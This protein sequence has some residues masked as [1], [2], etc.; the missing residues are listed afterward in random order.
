MDDSKSLQKV[1]EEDLREFIIESVNIDRLTSKSKDF[2]KNKKMDKVLNKFIVYSQRYPKGKKK[3]YFSKELLLN[4]LYKKFEKNISDI[5]NLFENGEDICPYLHR[6][7]KDFLFLDGLLMDWGII[8]LHL[9][10][11]KERKKS[12]LDKFILYAF[13]AG[14]TIGFIDITEHDFLQQ[15]LLQVIDD[16]WPMILQ[17]TTSIKGD[18][19]EREQLKTLRSKGY[20]YALE[21]NGKTF[22][23]GITKVQNMTAIIYVFNRLEVLAQNIFSSMD[24]IKET[25]KGNIKDAEEIDIHLG[26]D[27]TK[28]RV[29]LYD[30]ANSCELN[31]GDHICLKNLTDCF[32][33]HFLFE[34][35]DG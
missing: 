19:F 30:K 3:V 12:G 27:S 32:N 26:F 6:D 22:Y 14:N 29:F 5:K 4:P 24:N 7:I 28:K 9:F 8:H 1:F 18:A 31:I 16:N 25:I 17:T 11:V 35:N 23:G 2:I 21:V 33:Y 20:G 15:Y 13:V 34:N 10:P